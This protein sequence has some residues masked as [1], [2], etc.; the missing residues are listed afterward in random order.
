MSWEL[1]FFM[2]FSAAM[3]ICALGVVVLENPVHSAAALVGSFVNV[4]A[5]FVMLGAE[6][7]GVLQIIIYTGAILVLILLTVMLVDPDKLPS[8]YV[9]KPLQRNVSAIVG[10]LLLLEVGVVIVAREALELIGPHTNAVVQG[11]GGNVQAVGQVLLGEYP[12]AL[13]IAS[14]LLGVGVIGA[15]VIGLPNR[16]TPLSTASVSLGHTRGSSDMLAPGHKFESP[17]NI[18]PERYVAP[19]GERKIVMTRDADEYKHPGDTSK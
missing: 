4:A 10:A 6:F 11:M 3:L 18:P 8:F 2:V 12:L 9:G 13:E 17:M 16:D 15:V 5:L 14:I 7:L 19:Q 1:I